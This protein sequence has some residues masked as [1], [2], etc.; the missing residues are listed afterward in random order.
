MYRYIWLVVVIMNKWT[1][2][3]VMLLSYFH[4]KT[5][6]YQFN[7]LILGCFSLWIP[8]ILLPRIPHYFLISLVKGG[9]LCVASNSLCTL[10]RYPQKWFGKYCG[11][12]L[13][14][15]LGR[16]GLCH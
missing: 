9:T 15:H 2:Y 10:V 11:Q 7:A 13:P 5:S 1:S 6:G 12:N 8:T 14:Q 16:S 4:D 3:S